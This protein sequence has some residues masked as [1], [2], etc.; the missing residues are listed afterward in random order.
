MISQRKE[1][2]VQ[3]FQEFWA[4]KGVSGAAATNV[5]WQIGRNQEQELSRFRQAKL[6]SSGTSR[7]PFTVNKSDLSDAGIDQASAGGA[8]MIQ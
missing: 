3:W 8:E 7:V 6:R 1:G 2:A 5:V 4:Q